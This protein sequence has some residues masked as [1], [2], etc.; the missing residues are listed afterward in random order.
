MR[1][2]RIITGDAI[3]QR[4]LSEGRFTTSPSLHHPKIGGYRMTELEHH[5]LNALERLRK[6]SLDREAHLNGVSAQLTAGETQLQSLAAQLITLASQVNH[7]TAQ[8]D[9][10]QT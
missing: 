7:L 6:E 5:L 4:Q 10:F 1:R 9:Q 8:L 3:R 2:G